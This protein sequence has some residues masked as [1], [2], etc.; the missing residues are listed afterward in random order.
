MSN[1]TKWTLAQYKKLTGGTITGFIVDDSDEWATFIGLQVTMP[2]GAVKNVWVQRDTEGNGPGFL[3]IENDI[4]EATAPPTPLTPPSLT[5]PSGKSNT[6]YQ[7]EPLPNVHVGIDEWVDTKVEFLG[8]GE[9][10]L[11]NALKV[12]ALTDGEISQCNG[13]DIDDA[14]RLAD[15]GVL[16]MWQ[17]G[18]E[19]TFYL[20]PVEL[21]ID[22]IIRFMRRSRDNFVLPRIRLE[23]SLD[24]WKV[25][26]DAACIFD[27]V[28]TMQER[29]Q[30]MIRERTETVGDL[31]AVS[32]PYVSLVFGRGLDSPSL[33]SREEV[34]A[35]KALTSDAT[36]SLSA[37]EL[38]AEIGGPKGRFLTVLNGMVSWKR[39]EK[40]EEKRGRCKFAYRVTPDGEEWLARAMRCAD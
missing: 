1:Q 7:P 20:D 11:I 8:D 4:A 36:P 27:A 5:P 32:V 3:S 40:V 30:V 21:C 19:T 6:V 31:G 18:Q 17:D 15:E 25:M 26:I 35:L 38:H 2:S 13:Y 12:A 39:L 16:K 9:K 34:E 24:D 33:F 22:R 10:A 14:L 23:N 29:G 37:T 28:S